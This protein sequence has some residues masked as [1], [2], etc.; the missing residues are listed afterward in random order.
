MKPKKILILLHKDDAAFIYFK[1]LIKFLIREWRARG[2]EIEIIRG[3]DRFVR[4]DLVIPHLDLTIVPDE[5]RRFLD[6]YPHVMNR[7]VRDISKSTIS[8]NLVGRDDP[9][10]GPVIVKT[11]RNSGGLPE[12]RLVGR[13]HLLRAFSTRLTRA[14]KSSGNSVI[15]WADVRQL[16]SGDYPVF[17]SLQEVPR[18]VF[19]NRYLVVEKFLPEVSGDSYNVRY[20]HFFGDRDLVE[21][22]QSKHRVIK[23]S[24]AF[25]Y[26]MI[27]TPPELNEIRKQLGLDYGKIDY[28]VRDG[29]VVLLDVNPTP[30]LAANADLAR[31][32]ARHLADGIYAPLDG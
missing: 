1:Y 18:E 2:L 17:S 31:S 32:I 23:A 26:E 29:N 5:Y 28:V 3:I 27:P 21:L 25:H 22:Y 6:Q 30:G 24:A 9:Y 10:A 20:Y 19:D 4:A 16:K 14:V 11:D 8:R 7:S 13:K 12:I 15:Q